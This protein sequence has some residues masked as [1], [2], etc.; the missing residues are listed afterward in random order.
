M[1][2][3]KAYSLNGVS[4]VQPLPFISNV[5]P[6]TNF[7]NAVLGQ[8]WVNKTTGASFFFGGVVNGLSVWSPI[9]GVVN[10]TAAAGNT[11]NAIFNVNA[12][13]VRGTITGL[14]TANTASGTISVLNTLVNVDSAVS[15]CFSLQ[16]N[17]DATMTIDKIRTQAGVVTIIYTN[18][19]TAAIASSAGMFLQVLS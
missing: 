4:V 16:G 2:Y 14:N 1:E 19:G 13:L 7:S 11:A 17:E 18:N 3:I 5:D 6:S 9:N 12:R 10:A 8:Q 15:V